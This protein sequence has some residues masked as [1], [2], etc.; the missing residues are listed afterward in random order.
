MGNQIGTHPYLVL[1]EP[2]DRPYALKYGLAVL[3][4]WG[5]RAA[6]ALM[7]ING[8]G[9][10]KY[11]VTICAIFKNEAPYMREW[12]EFHKIVGIDHFYLYNNFSED[13]YREILA[14]YVEDGTVTLIDWPV[15]QGQLSAYTDAIRRFSEEA[16]WIGFIDLDEFVVPKETETVYDFLKRFS[17]R[18]SVLLHWRMY[19]SS[20]RLSRDKSGLVTEDHVVCRDK[21]DA[22]GKCFYNT[23]FSFSETDPRNGGFFHKCWTHA[24]PLQL[25]PVTPFG[26]FIISRI[27]R[28]EK[29][30]QPIQLNHYCTKSYEEYLGKFE[31][32]D[33]YFAGNPR[34]VGMFFNHER[35]CGSTDYS[36]YRYL[37]RLKLAL[38]MGKGK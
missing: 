34:S 22:M 6:L 9:Q 18:G 2:V 36:A 3:R 15:P 13:N 24:G 23:R 17:R 33:A 1:Q 19:G 20:G 21:Y 12:I 32:G 28:G 35:R 16:E 7:D 10:K 26:H 29:A 38:G 30:E 8:G 5:Y 37:V 4:E 11:K 25:P 27:Y 31:R 14:P